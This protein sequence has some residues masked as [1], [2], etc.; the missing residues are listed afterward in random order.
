MRRLLGALIWLPVSALFVAALAAHPEDADLML[1]ELV[2]G[3]A[4]G[5]AAAGIVA[6]LVVLV[7]FVANRVRPV[8][9]ARLDEPPDPHWRLKLVVADIVLALALA[10]FWLIDGHVEM[11]FWCGLVSGASIGFSAVGLVTRL[12]PWTKANPP[13]A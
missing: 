11:A 1:A 4:F 5:A 3:A 12:A 10:S 2:W 8:E 6:M 13:Q 7:G 9:P